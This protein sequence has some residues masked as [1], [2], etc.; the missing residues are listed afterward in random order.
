MVSESHA[1][2]EHPLLFIYV[3]C[4]YF[5]CCLVCVHLHF[6][7]VLVVCSAILFAAI[8]VWNCW[9]VL[10]CI[11]FVSSIMLKVIFPRL[12]Y[13]ILVA[14]SQYLDLP[15]GIYVFPWIILIIRLSYEMLITAVRLYIYNM[16]VFLGG[17]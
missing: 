15:T 4:Y 2:E 12:S 3:I 6:E 1:L 5:C 16:L 7:L 13:K 17:V 11:V 9:F 8:F 14:T 10:L